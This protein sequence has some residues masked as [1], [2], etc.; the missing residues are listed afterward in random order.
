MGGGQQNPPL[1]VNNT[2]ASSRFFEC[3][4]ILSIVLHTN[5]IHCSWGV[6]D[7]NIKGNP[8][9]E[10]HKR[11]VAAKTDLWA[12]LKY[13]RFS[14]S[15]QIS[16]LIPRRYPNIPLSALLKTTLLIMTVIR[17]S[18]FPNISNSS[19][20]WRGTKERNYEDIK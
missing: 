13:F 2:V 12:R 11:K 8:F 19:F 18:L 4:Y 10:L 9:S 14:R 1:E 16:R 3:T 7:M 20:G 5:F 15:N 17:L 6:E